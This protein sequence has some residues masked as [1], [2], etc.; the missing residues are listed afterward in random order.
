V[1]RRTYLADFRSQR[2]EQKVK[3]AFK[4]YA[5]IG[6]GVLV[7]ILVLILALKKKKK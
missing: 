4:K 1:A 2:S 6:G 3:K 7:G 5:L